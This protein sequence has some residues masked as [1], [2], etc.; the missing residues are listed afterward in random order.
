MTKGRA[1]GLLVGE[2]GWVCR[3]GGHRWLFREAFSPILDIIEVFAGIF[4]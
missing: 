1:S 2:A 3:D 4:E